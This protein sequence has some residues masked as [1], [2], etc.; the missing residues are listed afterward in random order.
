MI[1]SIEFSTMIINAFLKKSIALDVTNK[2][3]ILDN[4]SVIIVYLLGVGLRNFLYPAPLCIGVCIYMFVWN[5]IEDG[6][7]GGGVNAFR[8]RFRV[9]KKNGPRY[10]TFPEVVN[11]HVTFTMFGSTY[12]MVNALN[13]AI[14]YSYTYCRTHK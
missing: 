8:S 7:G 14:L 4:F 5:S 12:V 6:G 13:Y 2:Q 10:Q 9:K 1:F 3:F 11:L